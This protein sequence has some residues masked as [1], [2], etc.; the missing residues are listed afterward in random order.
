MAAINAELIKTE[1]GKLEKAG[2][3]FTNLSPDEAKR[4]HVMANE[5]RFEALSTKITP[6][7]MSKIKSLIVRN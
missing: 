7:Q 2:M 5:S 3:T 4:W 1:R 6:E